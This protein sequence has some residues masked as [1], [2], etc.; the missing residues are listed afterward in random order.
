MNGC[1]PVLSELIGL[2]FVS[3]NLIGS[4]LSVGGCPHHQQPSLSGT[5][6]RGR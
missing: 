5:A 2:Y 6:D 4:F 1:Y 3:R